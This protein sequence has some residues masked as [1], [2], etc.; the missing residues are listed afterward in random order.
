VSDDSYDVVI[1]GGG[2]AG[3]TTASLVRKYGGDAR[4]LVVEREAF[5]REHVG[6]SQLPSIG[7][8]LVEMGC[9]DDVERAGFPVKVGATFRW[10]NSPELWDLDFV[11]HGKLADRGRPRPWAGER[12]RTALQVER[13]RYDEILL[14]HA[15]RMGVEVREATAVTAVERDGDRVTALALSDGTTVRARYYVDASGSA[16]ILRRA[17]DVA[18]EYPAALK[19]VAA[20]SYWDDPRWAETDAVDGTRIQVLSLGYGWMWFILVGSTR[21]SVGLVV[22]ASYYRDSGKTLPELYRDA[23]A[24]DARMGGLLA[25]AA[26]DAD[27]RAIKDWSFVSERGS[28]EN[29]FLVGEAIGFADPILSAGMALA[30]NG[31]RELAHVLVSLLRGEHDPKWLAHHYEATQRARIRQHIRFADFWY[32]C[33]GQFAELK[34]HCQEIAREAGLHV[35]PQAAWQWLALG[36][37]THDVPGQGTIALYDLA[38]LKGVT[39]RLVDEPAVWKLSLSNRLDLALDGAVMLEVPLYRDGRIDKVRAFERNGRRLHMIGPVGLAA[40]FVP[41]VPYVVEL[42]DVLTRELV[43]AYGPGTD[44]LARYHA[45]QALELLLDDAWVRGSVEAGRPFVSM[46]TPKEGSLMHRHDDAAP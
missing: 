25:N 34:D 5:P 13:G 41:K 8:V 9:W 18:V 15:G 3:S 38:S 4:V 33:N 45:I 42:V 32:A 39:Q 46:S 37:F 44:G 1:I 28:G 10:G 14:R 21:A 31:G 20:W 24:S 16:G 36:G 19:N 6:E 17:M 43:A 2:P 27:V 35:A 23:L 11:P 29:W 12:T 22:P 7:A 26:P 40:K 30:H